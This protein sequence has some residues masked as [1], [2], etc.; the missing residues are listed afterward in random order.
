MYRNILLTGVPGIGKT[1]L[2]RRILDKIEVKAGGFCTEEIREKGRRV[3]FSINTL[4]GRTGTLAHVKHK[5]SA[6]T[7]CRWA[8][9]LRDD[10]RLIGTCGFNEWSRAQGW[11]E[12]AYELARSCWGRG[13]MSRA[14]AA[15][16]DWG[17]GTPSFNRVHAFVMVGNRRSERVLE[18]AG[19]TREG[20]L[21]SYRV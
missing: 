8:V 17:F 14:V 12:L 21:R 11:A 16:L 13:I 9:T 1:T 2:I 15:C 18:R 5:Y 3:G 6:G 7:G 4:D 20:C 19:F 10:D